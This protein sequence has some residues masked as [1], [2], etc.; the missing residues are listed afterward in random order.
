MTSV[1]VVALSLTFNG[2][3]LSW[4]YD[5]LFAV[6]LT[7]TMSYTFVRYGVMDEVKRPTDTLASY[8]SRRSKDSLGD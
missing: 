1:L 8:Q 3:G 6:W 7:Y 5:I 2:L 4:V